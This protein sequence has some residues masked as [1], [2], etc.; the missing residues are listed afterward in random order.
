MHNR[1]RHP[2]MFPT[3]VSPQIVLIIANDSYTVRVTV[4]IR[5]VP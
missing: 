3:M 5:I 1:L 2:A 4:S